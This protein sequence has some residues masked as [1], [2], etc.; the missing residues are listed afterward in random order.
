MLEEAKIIAAANKVQTRASFHGLSFM[1]AEH[2]GRGGY[3]YEIDTGPTGEKWWFKKPRPG[4]PWGVRISCHS[5]GL[6]LHGLEKKRTQIK[7]TSKSLGLLVPPDGV[8]IGRVDFAVG[9]LAPGFQFDPDSFVIH[10][11]SSHKT[12]ADLEEMQ[13]EGPSGRFSSTTIGKQP[14]RQV[15]VYDKRLETV[16][17]RKLE[18]PLVWNKNIKSMGRPSLYPLDRD[19]C[20]VWRVELRLGKR[21]LRDNAGIRG[22]QTFYNE[23]PFHMNKFA[24]DVSLHVASRDTNRSRWPL[25]PIWQQVQDE[26]ATK[27]FEHDV[28]V[29]WEEVWQ[30]SLSE[31]QYEFLRNIS[32]HA[33]TLCVLEGGGPTNLRHALEDLP[34]KIQEFLSL[35]PRTIAERCKAAREK[36]ID[37]LGG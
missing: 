23:L 30:A 19:G 18:W 16:K 4:G 20:Q 3:A 8:S 13:T 28:E 32:G 34:F 25:H 33:V 31:K 6:A 27:L 37:Y 10:S 1:V 9:I 15:I 35:H 14:G 22:W 5:L 12:H 21:A 11:R 7:S 29:P 36:Y 17:K 24:T 26:V 2:E